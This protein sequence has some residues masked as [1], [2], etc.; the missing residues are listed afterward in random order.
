MAK[1]YEKDDEDFS[2]RDRKRD[3]NGLR[4]QRR[5]QRLAARQ[6]R[7]ELLDPRMD[8]VDA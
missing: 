4:E 6:D 3:K 7:D 5:Q 8:E 2:P 1:W